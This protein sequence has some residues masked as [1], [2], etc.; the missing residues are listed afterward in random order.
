[1]QSTAKIHKVSLDDLERGLV[2][3]Y[4]ESG[5]TFTIEGR[6][7]VNFFLKQFSDMRKKECAEYEARMFDLN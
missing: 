6:E 5:K 3:S 2:V 7:I 4:G 1:V